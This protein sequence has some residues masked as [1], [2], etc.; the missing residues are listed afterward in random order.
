VHW[1]LGVTYVIYASIKLLVI[2]GAHS[3]IRWDEPLYRHRALRPV[4]WVVERLIST[5]ATH[6][7][8]HALSNADGVGHYK[9]NFGNLL[10]LWD[11]LFGT[12]KI[13]RRYPPAFGLNDDRR[14]G[15]E[16]WQVQMF[17]PLFRSQRR[18]TVLAGELPARAIPE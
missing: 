13:T 5:P 10:F 15:Q 1:G 18:E 12:A 14:W 2:V 16:R 6:F 11:V 17:F 8:H 3:T 4:A 9:G 7:A